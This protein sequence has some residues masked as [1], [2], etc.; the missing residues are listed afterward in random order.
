M[1]L[2][3][4]NHCVR[5]FRPHDVLSLS[6]T[7]PAGQAVLH[8][9]NVPPVETFADRPLAI[10]IPAIADLCKSLDPLARALAV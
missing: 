6:K 2:E 7:S 1:P 4:T 9:S 5:V 10:L 8:R 3:S